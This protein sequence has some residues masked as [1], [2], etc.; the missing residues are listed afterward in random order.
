MRLIRYAAAVLFAALLTPA[1]SA[2]VR[3]DTLRSVGGLPPHVVGMFEEPTSFQQARNGMYFVFDRRGHAVWTVDPGRTLPRKAVE[4]GGERGRI[5]QPYGFDLRPDG[6]FVVADV[7]RVEDRIQLFDAAGAWQGGFFIPDRPVA[8]VTLGNL[9]LSGIGSIRFGRSSLLVSYPETG[10]LFNEYSLTGSTT[11]SI[12]RL[13][14]TGF[15][16]EH[17]LHV[18]MNAGIPLMD[19]TGGY[20][21]V[22]ITGRPM[23]RKYDDAGMLLF[24]RHVEGRELDQFLADQPAQWPRRVVQDREMPVVAPVV[25]TAAVDRDGRLWI[26]LAV[27]FTYVYDREGDKTRT[28]QFSAAGIIS[29]ASL[30]FAPG[31]RLLVTPGCYEFDPR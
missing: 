6:T 18:A 15:E 13:R 29:P 1:P 10:A 25:R 3:V 4:I 31:G 11:R 17:D 27:P 7:P 23:F 24:E 16:Q 21:Y 20:Y 14:A 26:S 22:F 2:A 9:V 8:R 5:L 19:P 28:V 12:G 30:S